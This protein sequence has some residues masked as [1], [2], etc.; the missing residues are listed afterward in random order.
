VT[1]RN[2]DKSATRV[3]RDCGIIIGNHLTLSLRWGFSAQNQIKIPGKK[4]VDN[5]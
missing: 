2:A 1:L 5:I 4:S 3:L